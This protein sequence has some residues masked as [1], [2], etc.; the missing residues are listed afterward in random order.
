LRIAR[1]QADVK[2]P[3]LLH[4]I[5][6]QHYDISCADTSLAFPVRC[7]PIPTRKRSL[8]QGVRSRNNQTNQ[9]DLLIFFYLYRISGF[10]LD[11]IDKF[12]NFFLNSALAYVA[13][14]VPCPDR[15]G[16]HLQRFVGCRCSALRLLRPA[17]QHLLSPKIPYGLKAP[18]IRRVPMFGLA[19]A[20]ADF[21][22]IP[23]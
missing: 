14:R 6:I 20:Q 18:K 2:I 4:Q 1:Y 11:N 22:D 21:K 8:C 17:G 9:P 15:T 5:G 13:G 3:S 10:L 23:D 7:T 12:S 16:T 19:P